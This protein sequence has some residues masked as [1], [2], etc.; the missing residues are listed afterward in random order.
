MRGHSDRLK[1]ATAELAGT[2][3]E[4]AH[5]ITPSSWQ[6]VECARA[7]RNQ[8]AHRSESARD[9]LDTV[10]RET[11]LEPALRWTGPRKLSPAG[12]M[13]YLA[14]KRTGDADLRVAKFHHAL[15]DLAEQLRVP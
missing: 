14:T 13:R 9:V 10:V 8:L 15:S 12:T 3:R 11:N 5:A 7:I 2:Y 1:R 4:R 6:T